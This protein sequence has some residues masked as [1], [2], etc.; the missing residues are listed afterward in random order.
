MVH[1]VSRWTPGV[2]PAGK[3]EIPWVNACHT[4]AR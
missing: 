2:Q 1:F 4:W 3:T